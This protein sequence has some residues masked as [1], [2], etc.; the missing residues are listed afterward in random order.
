MFANGYVA[1]RSCH[2]R[3]STVDL[4]LY[5]LGTGELAPMG[6]GYDLMDAV[7]H[8]GAPGINE[9]EAANRRHLHSIMTASGFRSYVREWWHYTLK[10]EPYP[11]TYFDFPI[12]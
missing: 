11:G 8:H 1:A 3:G 2:S 7:S 10:D 9:V 5:H 6:G 4:T 12:S